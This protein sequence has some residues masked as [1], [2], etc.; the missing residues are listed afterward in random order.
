VVPGL[1]QQVEPLPKKEIKGFAH[2]QNGELRAFVELKYGRQGIWAQPFVHPDAQD[3]DQHLAILLRQLPGRQGRPL[4]ICV[5]SYQSWLEAAIEE[6][7]AQPG[8]PL[9]VMVHHLTVNQRV[10]QALPVHALNGTRTEP[11]APIARI[12]ESPHLELTD[13]DKHTGA[14]SITS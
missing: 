1:I 14:S 7:G 11:T 3:F 5:R 8:P 6:V 2:Y 13:A 12:E 10:K 4:Y 9:A